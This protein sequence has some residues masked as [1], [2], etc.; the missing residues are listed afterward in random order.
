MTSLIEAL[1]K[2]KKSDD[3]RHTMSVMA[4]GKG[5]YKVTWDPE[6]EAEVDAARKSFDELRKKG[7]AAYAVDRKGGKG[8][9]LNSFD[10]DA[11]AMIMA[12][13]LVGG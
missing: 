10:P 9:V 4:T 6:V 5:D 2:A 7:M 13:A 11:E 3:G 1:S 12:P 8:R